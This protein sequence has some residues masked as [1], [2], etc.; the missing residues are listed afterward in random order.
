MNANMYCNMLKQS[1]VTSPRKLD[2]M[3]IFQ[4]DLEH[5]IKRKERKVSNDPFCCQQFRH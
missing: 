3:A 4:R 1:V 5:T 2:R